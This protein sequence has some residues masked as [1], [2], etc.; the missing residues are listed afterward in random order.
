MNPNI[1]IAYHSD[2]NIE[3]IIPELIEIGLDILNPIQPK[4]MNPVKIKE[5]YGE[6]ITLWGA[7]DEQEILPF[8]KPEKVREETKYLK[9]ILGKSGGF[10]LSPTHH[11]QDD[12]P[13]ENLLVFYEEAINCDNP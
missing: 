13:I 4:C 2:G 8:A 11:V 12:T 6:K 5:I 9:K 10:I 7:L 3:P 1:K